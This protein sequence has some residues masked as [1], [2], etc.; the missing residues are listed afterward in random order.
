MLIWLEDAPQFQI[1]NDEAVAT[2]NDKIISCQN[3]VD[4]LELL[5]LVNRQVQSAFAYVIK[6]L[7][8]NVD[9]TIHSLQ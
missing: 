4:N 3:P 7:V 8:A 9:S 6:I 2:H 1:D 5:N